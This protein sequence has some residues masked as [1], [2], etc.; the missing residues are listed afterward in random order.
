[1]PES[2]V[3]PLPGL[4]VSH[5]MAFDF[6]TVFNSATGGNLYEGAFRTGNIQIER[7]AIE[8]LYGP[9][10]NPARPQGHP[11]IRE[12]D[13]E[14]EDPTVVVPG[15]PQQHDQVLDIDK[16]IQIN[17]T[18]RLSG[19][20]VRFI[21]DPGYCSRIKVIATNVTDPSKPPLTLEDRTDP[22][23]PVAKNVN[24]WYWQ[25]PATRQEL[26]FTLNVLV[27]DPK[28]AGFCAEDVYKLIVKWEFREKH[29]GDRM[30][31]SGYDE[32]ISFEVISQTVDL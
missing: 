17:H 28:A 2:F 21:A 8:E 18:G 32:A 19:S 22:L 16:A 23:T 7:P 30:P 11:L 29:T 9:L 6:P 1:M 10:G 14:A 31:I 3:N 27:R 5:F 20:F 12:R 25:N 24:V 26:V 13:P 4:N 15:Q